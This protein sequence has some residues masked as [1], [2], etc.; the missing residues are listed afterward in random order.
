VANTGGTI[1]AVGT[2][3]AV[4]LQGTTIDGG[5]LASSGIGAVIDAV[6]GAETLS[7][8]TISDGST[9][10]TFTGTVFDLENTTT[11]NGTV[12][13]EG[14]GTFV[15]DPGTASIVGGSGGGTLDIAVGATLT[16]SGDI[17]NG[18]TTA[19]ALSNSG[20]VDAD[21]DGAEIDIETGNY[22]VTN[23]GLLEATNGGT[24]AIE[25]DV[26]NACG[27]IGASGSGST[28]QLVGAINIAG[29]TLTTGNRFSGS[30]GVIEIVAV[31]AAE[32][33]LDGSAHAVTID[34]YVQVDAGAALAL[35]GT[36][37]N[38]GTINLASDS[39]PSSYL[40]IQTD[41]TLQGGG[42][43]TLT[44]GGENAIVTNGS[45]VTL[46]NV[47]NTISG[48]GTIGDRQY[49]TLV[50]EHEG[51]IDANIS[52]ATLTINTGDNQITNSGT[53]EAT[54]GGTL[55][56]DSSLDNSNTVLANHGGSIQIDGNVD[57]E[58]SGQ[59]GAESCG[60]I[61][62]DGFCVVNACDGSIT[63]ETGGAITFDQSHVD[64]YGQIDAGG[65]QLTFEHSRVDNYGGTGGNAGIGAG[66]CGSIL[67]FEY[68]HI[69]NN[70]NSLIQAQDGGSIVIEYSSLDN[71][72]GV[73]SD[74]NGIMAF[75]GGSVTIEYS[76]VDN[77]GL[78]RAGFYG[79]GGN[80]GTVYIDH[81]TI[82]NAGGTIWAVN[83][84]SSVQL[85][86]ATICGGTMTIGDGG[87]LQVAAGSDA[88]LDGVDVQN[89]GGII[90]V[91]DAETAATLI[92]DDGTT[93]SGGILSIES[94]GDVE[95]ANGDNGGAT[96]T[97]VTVR[98][99]GEVT[100]DSGTTLT[101]SGDTFHGGAIDGTDATSGGV[102]ASTIDVTGDSTFCDVSL[103]HGDLTVEGG[104]TLT[105]S[106]DTICDVAIEDGTVTSGGVTAGTIDVTGD[107][108]FSNVAL[109]DGNLTVEGGVTLTLA[110]GDSV[111]GTTIED[112]TVTSGGVTA[113]TIDVT[114]DT[115]F[116][117]VALSD[118]NLTVEGGVTLSVE[119]DA[120]TTFNGVNVTDSGTI[121]VDEGLL[122]T[123][124]LLENA[125]TISGG[126][127]LSI[128]GS[129][130][131][132]VEGGATLDGLTVNVST[133]GIIEVGETT[134]E[135]ILTLDDGTTVAGGGTGQLTVNFGST[136]DVEKGTND[137]NNGATLDDVQVQD[138]GAIDIGD[139]ANGATLTL[140]DGTTITGGGTAELN[141]NF[142]STVDVEAGENGG[143]TF[144]DVQ[145]TVTGALDVGDIAPGATLTLE[146]GTTIQGFGTVTI[147]AGNTVDV[148]TGLN[149]GATLYGLDV[150]D[151]GALDVGD[152]LGS[153]ATLILENGTSVTGGGTGT[154]T[155]NTGN[156]LEVEN[157]IDGS[158]GATL[159]G[160]TITDNGAIN[161]VDVFG[162]G[163]TLTLDDG[164]TIAGGGLGTLTI[165][166]HSTLDVE[167]GNNG[168][169]GATLDGVE[170]TDSGA[171]VV[172][173]TV[174]GATL[175]LDDG[176]TI[177]GGGTISA[178]TVDGH[179]TLDVENGHS[180]GG[181]TLDGIHVTEYGAIVVGE[182][183]TGATLTLDGGTTVL[184][185]G[186]GLTVDSGSTLAI[187][188]GGATLDGGYVIDNG[189]IVV[190]N[191][192]SDVTLT[193]LDRV[194][195]TGGNSGT[196]TINSG[197]T[198][199]IDHAGATL[200][201][202]NVTL[203]GA[204]NVD[205]TD[206]AGVV[207]ILEGGTTL[208]GGG[209]GTVTVDA[210]GTLDIE[211]GAG[212]IGPNGAT[213]DD[214]QVTVNGALD[215]GDANTGATLTL[216][217]GTTVCGSGTL[218]INGGDTLSVSDATIK[219]ITINGTDATSGGVIAS[220]IDVT[221]DSTFCDISVNHGDLTV[222]SGVTLTLAAGDTV[223][224]VTITGTNASGDIVASTIDVTGDTTFNSVSLSGGDLTVE[225]DVTLTLA[226][227]DT[228]SDVTI[229][230]TN[231][232]GNI[233][234]STIDVTGD[235]TFNSV[236]L[237]GG[238]LT[239]ESDVTLSIEGN[240]TT[241]TFDGVFVT[242]SGS[243]Q[244]DEGLPTTLLLENGT[245][246]S[247][248]GT[249]SIGATGV[250]DVDSG[251]TTID[252]GGT[253]TN[254]G[255]IEA[256]N[257]GILNIDS[258]F[259]NS[260]QIKAIDGGVVFIQSDSVTNAVGGTITADGSNAS[261]VVIDSNIDTSVYDYGTL[262]NY[263][264]ITSSNGGDI[265]INSAT[266]TNEVGGAITSEGA[267]SV[268]IG[269]IG[270][271]DETTT[272]GTLSNYGSITADSSYI[273][274]ESTTIT[275]EL[276]GTIT[277]D[278]ATAEIDFDDRASGVSLSN[279]GTITASDDGLVII[280]TS[281]VTNTG[282]F[283]ATGGGELDI[284]NSVTDTGGT[285]LAASG[286]KL[287]V[288]GAICGG[289]ATIHAGILEFDASSNV[290]VTF[291]NGSG[292]DYGKLVLSDAE[293]FCGTISDFTG[294]A[295]N[296]ADSDVIDLTDINFN[297]ANFRECY[298]SG[299]GVLMVTDGTDTA[300]LKF[301]DF[302][303]TFKFS[304]DGTNGTDIYD[305]PAAG[306]KDVPAT[307]TAAPGNN[308][309]TAPANQ[310]ES[311]HAAGPAIETAFGGDQGS[312]TATWHDGDAAHWTNQL[313]PASA[314][315]GG[316]QPA[317]SAIDTA[318][319]IDHAGVGNSSEADAGALT[320][321]SLGGFTQ[322]LLSSLLN[323]LAD[324][325][326][327]IAVVASDVP[328]LDS[329]HPTDSTIVV[330]SST[331]NGADTSSAPPTAPGNEHV[332]ALATVTPPPAAASPTLASATF[333]TS[334]NDSFAF[335]PNLG[336]DTAHTTGAQTN[337]LAHNNVQ[338]AGSA[339]ASIV[340]EFHQ[341]FAFDAI[342]QDVA[343][344]A[345]D[346]FH[347]MAANST[348]L[349]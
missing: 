102:I 244:V 152:D 224:D 164:T 57:N 131:L 329:E 49:L 59:I 163:A 35:D 44:D 262:S 113:G 240:G 203:D 216:D 213:F 144:D 232:S 272:F 114:G 45:A 8:V 303:G 287:D 331:A 173:D 194:E 181:A 24:L 298:N 95:I 201:G 61:T 141:I 346:Q 120:T 151:K 10:Q 226:A 171:I 150:I 72:G 15:L 60:T 257:G 130:I 300:Y 204:L 28:V 148:E 73:V 174:S 12:T 154:M 238:D 266:V 306:A 54:C 82:D 65:G 6:T 339:L 261:Q 87:A 251:T 138:N 42:Q 286:G 225:S 55:V 48:A 221:G 106:G 50:N 5:T 337:E 336:N 30:G 319:S 289:T 111:T 146:D 294:T 136:L 40:V 230:G 100:I 37:D 7:G 254:D 170:V 280:D 36:I 297:S 168:G 27:T 96:L 256:E 22:T 317:N 241:T 125:T 292:T 176:T 118:G 195:I 29:G 116:S 284:K 105:L 53:L 78:I 215:I 192:D 268:F 253:I 52:G 211:R 159:D 153:P 296:S 250:V 334:G 193:L 110:A 265:D 210:N 104:V 127:I 283:E 34:G 209:V 66:G 321:G 344:H 32:T 325:T 161:I 258:D 237:S 107:T 85:L 43:V 98:N 92:L 14:G 248:S 345:V 179:S 25:S 117:N 184:G 21:G 324:K 316:H 302:T 128:G 269:V 246:I 20:T 112:G 214:V 332:V 99:R 142:G 200:D 341:E 233:V 310:I 263:G 348:L 270:N 90:Q 187:D 158:G 70:P 68:C 235:T 239:V 3:A 312:A 124:L 160:L 31:A 186:L 198:L 149:G 222:E 293:H 177:T 305:P 188:G 349:H 255:T 199:A 309:A 80:E 11:L 279:F 274:I 299:N 115:T 318:F 267:S 94:C 218:T 311:A 76:H 196:L 156:T 328:L 275:N 315:L 223:S 101:L 123:T 166:L 320:S 180:G 259:T 301:D 304:S 147:N 77:T 206:E 220:T 217:D 41:V 134:S 121:Q 327:P 132:D 58:S 185:V 93:V 135:S 288:E 47:N 89:S 247:G 175:T 39:G 108:T 313:V 291:D 178:L 252:L 338:I 228:V 264:T 16:G 278:G 276:G 282:S 19:L 167:N 202:V 33:I 190:G 88:T 140:E 81:S 157:G 13:F 343:N 189:A 64:N 308:H 129:G 137:G 1:E 162:S 273:G 46:T 56:I 74:G 165:D 145:A 126:G 249:L 2:N 227:G 205:P 103:S 143:A 69:V 219:H 330:G 340:P 335:H 38:E 207:L 242:D 290:N 84:G 234:A 109:S 67:T 63:A 9:L 133:G 236:S 295:A 51:T 342:H 243:I 231:A 79:D 139:V 326:S 229:T 17:G 191:L 322:T 169:G 281:T 323:V 271:G 83:C 285:L 86:D 122:T 4:W 197:D 75:G 245:T 314:T 172:V 155:I 26:N 18:G 208:S 347:Q 91:E 119:G 97:D 307:A 71:N 182:V 183:H 277:A 62:F 212:A 23:A 333:G 260:G